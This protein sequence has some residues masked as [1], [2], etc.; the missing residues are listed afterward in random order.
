MVDLLEQLTGRAS[1]Q[2]HPGKDHGMMVS[3]GGD[4]KTVTAL[5]VKRAA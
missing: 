4:D 5:I 1:S 2:T 3:M